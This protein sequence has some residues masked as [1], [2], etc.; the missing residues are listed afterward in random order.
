MNRLR[1]HLLGAGQETCDYYL[2]VTAGRS[3]P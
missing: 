2:I 3:L 1:E